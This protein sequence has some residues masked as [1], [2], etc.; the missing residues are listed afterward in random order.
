[1]RRGCPRQGRGRWQ[2]YHLAKTKGADGKEYPA[3][4]PA[5]PARPTAAHTSAKIA[6][7]IQPIAVTVGPIEDEAQ[8]ILKML[9]A[10]D[11]SKLKDP[12]TFAEALSV[13]GT[14][15]LKARRH[16]RNRRLHC[17]TQ[18]HALAHV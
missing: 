12:E 11:W 9:D 18:R 10:H 4:K 7:P 1:D 2:N 6:R 5:K 8:R 13:H 3:R 14:R 17:K 16:G 15:T